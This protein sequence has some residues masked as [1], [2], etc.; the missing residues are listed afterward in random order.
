MNIIIK[1]V[2]MSYISGFLN[3]VWSTLLTFK[4]VDAVD[5]II[6]AYLLFKLIVLVKETRAEQLVKGILLLLGAYFIINLL[7]LKAMSFLFQVFFQWG[8]LAIIVMFQPELRRALEKVGRTKFKNFVFSSSNDVSENTAIWSECIDEVVNACTRLSM[9]KTGALIVFERQTKLGE[10]IDTGTRIDARVSAEILENIFVPNTPLHD[11]A[12][13]IRDGK[14]HSAACFL[15]KPQ[16]EQFISKKLGS[17]H[18]AA[19]GMSEQ[20][21]ALI[22]VVSE[23]T[24]RISVAENGVLVTDLNGV[25]LKKLLE[26]NL[27]A[28]TEKTN[29]KLFSRFIKKKSTDTFEQSDNEKEGGSDEH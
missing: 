10:Q 22:V 11:G 14:I 20:S 7:N 1:E 6:L 21:D 13:I 18:R 5:I 17:R 12:V 3:S 29:D 15:P 19:I 26:D 25:S 16:K 24:G 27:I 8:I 9:S 23:E 4:F 28:N 2:I